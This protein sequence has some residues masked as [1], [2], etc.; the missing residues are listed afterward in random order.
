MSGFTANDLTR[1][2]RSC[3]GDSNV[4]DLDGSA[5][6]TPI[7]ELGYDSLAML[8]VASIVQ[9]EYGVPIPDEALSYMTTPRT[10]IEYLNSRLTQAGVA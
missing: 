9:R 5:L 3:G 7:I 4:V 1:I 10:T 6:D 8:E 2:L